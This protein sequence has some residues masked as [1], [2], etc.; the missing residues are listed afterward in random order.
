MLLGMFNREK[1]VD[2]GLL[3]QQ[4]NPQQIHAQSTTVYR[5]LQSGYAELMGM[6]PPQYYETESYIKS[7]H[8]PPMAVRNQLIPD[9][10]YVPIPLYNY[11]SDDS[12]AALDSCPY[13]DE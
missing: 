1:Y 10:E 13:A 8:L 6:Y 7:K 9:L 4:Y 3:D 11:L 5:A 12:R 2:G